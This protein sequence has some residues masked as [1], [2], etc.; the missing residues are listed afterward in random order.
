ML[1][2]LLRKLKKRFKN[3]DLKKPFSQFLICATDGEIFH[4]KG[5][6]FSYLLQ[7]FENYYI[8]CYEKNR[9]DSTY[10]RKDV[11]FNL[12]QN[13]LEVC[14]S[15]HVIGE[16]SAQKFANWCECFVIEFLGIFK[17]CAGLILFNR[18]LTAIPPY[19]TSFECRVRHFEQFWY[20]K[21]VLNLFGQFK[22][23]EKL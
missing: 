17:Y 4:Q 10:H 21:I 1:D 14:F 12:V 18:S 16:P 2:P 5:M 11:I 9:G 23:S 6:T 15:T 13:L 3:I 7:N 20:L 22:R 8:S 19:H